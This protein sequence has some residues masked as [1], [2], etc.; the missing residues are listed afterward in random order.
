MH[1]AILQA[2]IIQ[3]KY[4]SHT[5]N[6]KHVYETSTCSNTFQLLCC[7]C[8]PLTHPRTNSTCCRQSRSSFSNANLMK[9]HHRSKNILVFLTLFLKFFN[10]QFCYRNK[11]YLGKKRNII[12][13]LFF[14]HQDA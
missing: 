13:Y 1:S 2:C 6:P 5:H 12:L 10:V 7:I 8:I 14:K 4:Q 3:T 9:I 11:N